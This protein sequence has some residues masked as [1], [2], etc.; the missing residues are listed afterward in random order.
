MQDLFQHSISLWDLAIRGVT[1]YLTV[2]VL[3]RISGKKQMGQMGPTEFVAILLISNAVQNSM[4]GGYNSLVGG[5]WLAIV[6]IALSALL[7][8]LTYRS[9]F[10]S[11]F[12]EGTPR[13]VVHKGH[14]LKDALRK[15]RMS[16]AELKTLIRKQG[17]HDC[18]EIHA[19]I[20]E[21]DGYLSVVRIQ[22]LK[23][24][25]EWAHEIAAD[26]KGN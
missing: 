8:Y 9:R 5:L 2:L 6:L 20:L 12:F 26:L 13:L 17:F 16:V 3:L 15:E 22:D 7:S 18:R 21:S 10:F 14:I 24:H 25:P 1:V 11:E 4:N 23:D 19:A